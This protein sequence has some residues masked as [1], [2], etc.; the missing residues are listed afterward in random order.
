MTEPRIEKSPF[1]ALPDGT[2]VDLYRL[3]GTG[4]LRAAITSYGGAVVSLEVPD[5]T[6]ARADVILGFD[7]LDGYLGKGNPYFGCIV[8]RYGNLI[9]RGRF[10]LE[11]R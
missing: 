5:R 4:G 11:G 3:T 7:G 2:P 8:G 10:T 1:G 9:G 6:G